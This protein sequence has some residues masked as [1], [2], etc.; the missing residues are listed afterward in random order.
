MDSRVAVSLAKFLS[1]TNDS[2]HVLSPRVVSAGEKNIVAVIPSKCPYVLMP[3]AWAVSWATETLR[4][5]S[6][7]PSGT[8]P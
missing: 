8:A 4:A 5:G 2:E 6:V 1:Q 3:S 7:C